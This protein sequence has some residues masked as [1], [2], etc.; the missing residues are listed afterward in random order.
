MNLMNLS[1]RVGV[2][3]TVHYE[4]FS[5]LN[6]GNV[7]NQKRVPYTDPNLHSD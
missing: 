6:V 7:A 3:H 5:Y 1:V 2:Y 4:I